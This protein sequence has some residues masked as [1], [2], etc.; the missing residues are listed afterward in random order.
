[1]LSSRVREDIGRLLLLLNQT[2]VIPVIDPSLQLVVDK[3]HD[4][5]PG[6]AGTAVYI[7]SAGIVKRVHEYQ[8]SST[9]LSGQ[10][11]Q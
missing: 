5:Y 4:Y 8:S 9:V 2:D 10:P 1:M 7:T 11:F 3:I 6:T